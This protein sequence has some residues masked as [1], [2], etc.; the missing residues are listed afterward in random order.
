MCLCVVVLCPCVVVLCPCVVVLCLSVVVLCLWVVVVGAAVCFPVPLVLSSCVK[1]IEQ[2]GVVDGM[3][4][5]S[6]ISSN[7]HKLRCLPAAAAALVVVVVVVE[8]ASTPTASVS[9][10]G[11]EI[12][13]KVRF[14]LPQLS[15]L[16]GFVGVGRSHVGFG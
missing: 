8:Q 4:R 12:I 10:P 6:G 1:A 7:I 16:L 15:K 11:C 2:H 3:Y 14:Y 13:W 5:L 9:C